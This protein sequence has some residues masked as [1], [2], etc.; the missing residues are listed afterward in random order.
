MMGLIN[1]STRPHF[2]T[3]STFKLS[4]VFA[5]SPFFS[6]IAILI[7]IFCLMQLD[8][9]MLKLYD[10]TISNLELTLSDLLGVVSFASYI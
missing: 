1:G 8:V 7:S 9:E 10:S 3:K 2:G 6:T 4:L 5:W